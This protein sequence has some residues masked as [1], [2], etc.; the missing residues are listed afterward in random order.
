MARSDPSALRWLIGAELANYRKESG[1]SLSEVSA[2]TGIG[3]AKLSHMETGR[4]Q[5]YPDD[6]A[7]VLKVYGVAQRDIDRLTSLAGRADSKTWW[8]PW[9]H[10]VPDWFKTFV[11][12]EGL[13][14]SEFAYEPIVVP[15]L[16][17]TE[18]YAQELTRASGFVRPDHHERFVSFRLARARRLTEEEPLRLHAVIGEAALRLHVGTPEIRRAQ[19]EH[20]LDLADRPNVTVQVLRP[21][22]GPH[23]A[24]TG[25]FTIMDFVD[26]RSIAY[27]ELLDGAVY[28]QDPDDVR[29][30][31]M[32]AENLQQV[33][34]EPDESVAFI[35]SLLSAN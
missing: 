5:Q 24:V 23:T 10:V 21:E 33:A 4:Y 3:R 6:I 29:T 1:L 22:N 26:V 12:L 9:A 2:A 13:A 32:A 20:L 25:K 30:Y 17:Q 11:G 8:A 19:Y 27:V 7:A 16:L 34:L 28:V 31:K 15:G 14:E 18:A 35:K